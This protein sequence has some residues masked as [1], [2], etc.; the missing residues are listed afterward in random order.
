MGEGR[1]IRF[2]HIGP[3]EEFDWRMA[4]VVSINL[5]PL[6][7]ALKGTDYGP[8]RLAA[9]IIEFYG[10]EPIVIADF[11]TDMPHGAPDYIVRFAADSAAKRRFEEVYEEAESWDDFLA[12]L[13]EEF[14]AVVIEVYDGYDTAV[15]VARPREKA[16]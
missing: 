14:D 8:W 5:E 9:A 1:V 16:G 7:D 10:G 13:A 4:D 3:R 12:T 15:A 11:P 2:V 6:Y